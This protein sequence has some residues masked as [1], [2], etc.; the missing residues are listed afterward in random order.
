M[1]YNSFLRANVHLQANCINNFTERSPYR[2]DSPSA[3]QELFAFHENWKFFP[4]ALTNGPFHKPEEFS[5]F[6]VILTVHR[7]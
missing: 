1:Q 2:F 5:E 4:H 6:D 7:R 3:S